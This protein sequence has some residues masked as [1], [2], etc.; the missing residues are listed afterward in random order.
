MNR[1]Q[2]SDSVGWLSITLLTTDSGFEDERVSY[3]KSL[4]R[5]MNH[6]QLK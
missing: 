5:H 1:R 4:T 3:K 2:I 6:L